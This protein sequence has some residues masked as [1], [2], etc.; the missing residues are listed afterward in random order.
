MQK[1]KNISISFRAIIEYIIILISVLMTGGVWLRLKFEDQTLNYTNAL[2]F[3]M[4]MMYSTVT[5]A[6]KKR[7]KIS[8]AQ[9]VFFL[10]FVVISFFLVLVHPSLA[11]ETSVRIIL[12]I[13]YAILLSLSMSNQQRLVFAKRYVNII[14]VIAAISLFFYFGG[15]VIGAIPPTGDVAVKWEKVRNA[16]SYFNLYYEFPEW[17]QIDLFGLNGVKNCAIFI[18]AP[19]YSFCLI[20]A[21]LVQKCFLNKNIKI[22]IVL[23]VAMITAFNTTSILSILIFEGI[24]FMFKKLKNKYLNLLKNF[25]IPVLIIA[26]WLFLSYVLDSKYNSSTSFSIRLDHL[27]ACLNAWKSN[28]FFGVGFTNKEGIYQYAKYDQG[29]SVGLMYFIAQGGL[30]AGIMIGVPFIKYI[31][32]AFKQRNARLI[33]FSISFFIAIFLT[34][35]TYNSS[36]QWFVLAL[37]FVP[38]ADKCGGYRNSEINCWKL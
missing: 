8:K 28:L 24:C 1:T 7:V 16:R 29:M 34:N 25:S 20:I 31:V 19:M 30:L 32:N 37:V 27:E 21:Y 36:L 6:G 12:P 23:I 9:K 5:L 17:Q 13:T 26:I 10:T 35:V 4:C 2:I 11:A 14:V 18:E 38:A 3:I 15:S 22:Q 33:G